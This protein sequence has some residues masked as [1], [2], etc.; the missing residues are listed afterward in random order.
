[1]HKPARMTVFVLILLLQRGIIF[2][3]PC[4]L[5]R[6]TDEVKQPWRL[7]CNREFLGVLSS[8]FAI[9]QSTLRYPTRE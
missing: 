3:L 7:F 1:M 2:P 6:I 4:Y 5:A 9:F 8:N